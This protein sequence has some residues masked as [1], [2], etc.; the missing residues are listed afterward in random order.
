MSLQC[1]PLACKTI[2]IKRSRSTVALGI[3]PTDPTPFGDSVVSGVIQTTYSSALAGMP[4]GT[5]L[6]LPRER[7]RL[8][9]APLFR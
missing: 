4:L 9:I 7:D 2:L 5:G 1:D 8:S 6:A 3:E